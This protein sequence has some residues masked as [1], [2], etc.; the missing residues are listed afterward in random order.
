M[1]AKRRNRSSLGHLSGSS[2]DSATKGVPQS[3]R[4]RVD[5]GAKSSR[6]RREK[7]KMSMEVARSWPERSGSMSVRRQWAQFVR[8]KRRKGRRTENSAL[9]RERCR[10]M[11]RVVG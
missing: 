10:P 6:R 9:L 1:S 7:V 5:A 8:R 2:T 3:R 11:R 4:R